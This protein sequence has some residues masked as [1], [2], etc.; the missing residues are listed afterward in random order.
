MLKKSNGIR[1]ATAKLIKRVAIILESI[2]FV[3]DQ[4]MFLLMT[5]I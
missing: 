5:E 3:N 4:T 2:R 1:V